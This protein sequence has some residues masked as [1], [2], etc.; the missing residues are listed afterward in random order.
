MSERGSR[1][2]VGEAV[3]AVTLGQDVEWERCARLATPA[4]RRALDRL[5]R[6]TRLFPAIDAAGRGS[7]AT[8]APF[9]LGSGFTRRAVCSSWPSPRSRW[10]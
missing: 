6:F 7:A 2:V 5:R 3:D 10:G 9:A 8:P 4:E 1:D